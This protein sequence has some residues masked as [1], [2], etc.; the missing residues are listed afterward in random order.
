MKYEHANINRSG[1]RLVEYPD[2]EVDSHDESRDLMRL[3]VMNLRG[4]NGPTGV[5]FEMLMSQR[6]GIIPELTEFNYIHKTMEGFGIS[7]NDRSYFLDAWPEEKLSRTT[8]RRK[9]TSIPKLARALN[10]TSELCQFRQIWGLGDPLLRTT[11]KE[12]ME[13]IVAKGYDWELLMDT[14]SWW[15]IIDYNPDN[16]KPFLSNYDLLRMAEDKYHPYWYP[17]TRAEMGLPEIDYAAQGLVV[18]M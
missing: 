2:S 9:I 6:V 4:K 17:K 7:G 15:T 12:V 1:A 14:R 3:T 11:P 18:D 5:P 10:F 8:V 16:L 13:K